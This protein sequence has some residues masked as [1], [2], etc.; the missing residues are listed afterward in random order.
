MENGEDL[1]GPDGA[2]GDATSKMHTRG[3]EPTLVKVTLTGFAS[4]L[5]KVG[6]RTRAGE[7]FVAFGTAKM[8][9]RAG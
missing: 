3:T 8:V 7:V 2:D 4:V 5:R 9:P 1:E 6:P